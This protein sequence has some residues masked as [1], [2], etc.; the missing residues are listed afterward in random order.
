VTDRPN[1]VLVTVD[2]LRAD[3]CGFMGYEKDTTPNLDGMAEDGVVFEN[4]IAPGPSTP[5][6]MPAVFT[7]RYPVERSTDADS[8]LATRRERIHAHMIARDTLPE[9]MH[10]MGYHT[11]AFTPNPFT[12]R[13][14][15]FDQGFD[16]FRDFMTGSGRE[17]LYQR[18][19]DGFLRGSAVS[20]TA[21]M[22]WNLWQREEVFKPW[23][24]YYDEVTEWVGHATEPY[25][26]WVFL[27]DAHNPYLSPP[28][29]RSQPKTAEFHANVE[30]WRQS[31]ET[32]FAADVHEKLVTAY[33]DAVR[34]A[35]G[36]LGRLGADLDDAV[37]AVHGDHGEA[38]GEHGSYGH[39]PHVY[40][41]NTRVPF[42]VSGDGDS[43][44]TEAVSL[45]S[46]PE[47]LVALADG[48]P[49]FDRRAGLAVSYTADGEAVAVGTGSDHHVFDTSGR[50]QGAVTDGGPAAL[51]ERFRTHT[52]E[53]TSIGYA[54][55]R[56]CQDSHL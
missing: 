54:T 13:H 18:L 51:A 1:I 56:V 33:D 47:L 29:Y 31:H 49:A 4:A 50:S 27:M 34:Y 40:A 38:F 15:G 23:E 26:L 21:R 16:H 45:R 8:H 32:P 37:V 53:V 9:K 30:F 44:V 41:E 6:S 55:E 19:F 39:E 52:D 11:A 12:S 42:V 22:V 7:G 17:R 3:H 35:D 14:F 25:F 36:F 48:S 2:S 20:S 10:R 46:L 24:A 43:T 28:E 5:E